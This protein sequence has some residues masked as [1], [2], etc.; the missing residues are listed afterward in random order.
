ML[1]FPYQ[2]SV[3]RTLYVLAAL[4]LSALVGG[5]ALG[6]L[7][8]ERTCRLPRWL[9][10]GLSGALLISALMHLLWGAWDTQARVYATFIFLGM[11]SGFAGDLIMARL[12]RVPNRLVFGMAAFGVGHLLYSAAFWGVCKR[13]TTAR[14]GWLVA[15]LA[16]AVLLVIC[17]WWRLIR[18]PGGSRAI[19]LGS[20]G[21]AV[22]IALMVVLSLR[23]ATQVTCLT[24]LGV[25]ALLFLISDLVLGN[26]Q[27]RGHAWTSVNDLIWTTYVLGQL[28]IVSSVAGAVACF[29]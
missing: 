6:R 27:V 23:V 2:A 28:L 5:L 11:L 3:A 19:N 20:L 17:A 26:W 24:G 13:L 21:Y 10:I 9:R 7:N 22:L 18:K 14:P 25:G 8:E 4:V 12:V 29:G 16:L 15:S 1:P